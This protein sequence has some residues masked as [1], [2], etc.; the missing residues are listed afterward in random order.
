MKKVIA[1][2]LMMMLVLGSA[3]AAT[4]NDKK[5][6]NVVSREAGSG[7]RGA[8]IE[9]FGIEVKAKTAPRK[10]PPPKKLSSPSRPT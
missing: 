3:M 5:D 1:I 9:L 7:T 6:I 8:F 2:A 10:I 4:F